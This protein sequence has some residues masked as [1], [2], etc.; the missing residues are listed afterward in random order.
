M[1]AKDYAKFPN[2]RAHNA[3]AGWDQVDD[4]AIM[5]A[6]RPTDIELSRALGRTV[7]AVHMRRHTLGGATTPGGTSASVTKRETPEELVA[8]IDPAMAALLYG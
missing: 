3:H 1:T 7:Q 6:D 4:T 5:A 8:R 2:D